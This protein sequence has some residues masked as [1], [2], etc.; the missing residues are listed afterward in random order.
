MDEKRP[1]RRQRVLKGAKIVYANGSIVIDCTMRNVSGTG[2]LLKVPTTVGI[3]DRFELRETIGSKGRPVVV[4]WRKA[5]QI[6]I[7][8]E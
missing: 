6:G 4:V 3:P 5:G 1:E 7:R 8:F 2:A